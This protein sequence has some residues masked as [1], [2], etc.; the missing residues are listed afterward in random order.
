[1]NTNNI[2][3]SL[4]TKN[5]N[6]YECNLPC[7]SKASSF[8]IM[9]PKES[10]DFHPDSYGDKYVFLTIWV[11][12][13]KH[14]WSIYCENHSIPKYSQVSIAFTPFKKLSMTITSL[15]HNSLL[16]DNELERI[17]IYN[18]TL[19]VIWVKI[20][21]DDSPD[22]DKNKGNSSEIYNKNFYV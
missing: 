11:Q 1:M 10:L 15:N 21:P 22:T 3:D 6:S 4:V 20:G 5:M 18:C 12:N 16:S 8:T 2:L 13:N 9:N 19:R 14:K 17:L 7:V